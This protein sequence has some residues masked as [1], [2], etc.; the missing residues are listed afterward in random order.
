MPVPKELLKIMACPSCHKE[1]EE[2][3]MF[4]ICEHCNKAYPVLS[5]TIPDML[6]EDAWDLEKAKNAG[7]KHDLK[8]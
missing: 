8:L 6:E 1:L 3:G 5:E 2:K 7:F 4:L